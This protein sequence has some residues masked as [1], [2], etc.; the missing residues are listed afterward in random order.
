MAELLQPD[1]RTI[2][3]SYHPNHHEGD[4]LSMQF[5]DAVT[6]KRYVLTLDPLT[7]DYLASLFA[8]AVQSP[9][10]QARADQ[11]KAARREGM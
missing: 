7:A 5:D 8:T 11:M 6:G 3:V 4:R 10:V 1:P 9:A 2:V